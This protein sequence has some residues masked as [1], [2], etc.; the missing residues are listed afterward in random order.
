[1]ATATQPD[2]GKLG[3]ELYKHWEKAMGSW[4]DQVLESPQFLGAMGKNLE[5]AAKARGQ[6][7]RSVDD[8]ME[9]MHLPTRSDVVRVAKIAAML[10][11]RLLQQ[12][13]LVLGLKDQVVAMQKEA[14][15]ARIE[16]AEARIEL[17]ETLAALR[18]ELGRLHVPAPT[19][20]APTA[21]TAPSATAAERAPRGKKAGA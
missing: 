2:I 7:E 14:V 1:M 5:H 10:E 4:W 3:D 8:T 20:S 16:A 9:R 11:E 15:Q 13:D 6:Y 12:E 21:A 19:A 17:R 18:Q